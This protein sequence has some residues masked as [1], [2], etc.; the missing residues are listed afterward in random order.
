MAKTVTL[1]KIVCPR[2]RE[3]GQF[4]IY[5][6]KYGSY[7]YVYHYDNDGFS[8]MRKT[9]LYNCYIGKVTNNHVRC[10]VNDEFVNLNLFRNWLNYCEMIN[11]EYI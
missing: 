7:S 11:N 9:Y 8:N 4:K 3:D 5:V 6:R 10:I 2:C 1:G